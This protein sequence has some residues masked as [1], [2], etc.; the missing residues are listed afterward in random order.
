MNNVELIGRIATDVKAGNGVVSSLIAVHRI[1]KSKD[2]IEA[3]FIPLSLFG[4]Q[5]ENF[6]KM[7]QKGQQVGID[8][9]IKTSEYVDQNGEKRYGWSVVVSHF[10][11][12]NSGSHDG[13]QPKLSQQ[14]VSDSTHSA[15]H[16]P[17]QDLYN[18]YHH[19]QTTPTPQPVINKQLDDLDSQLVKAGIPFD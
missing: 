2:G 13:G 17:Q 6:S 1:Y 15:S 19:Q 10:Y 3:D 14:T 9:Q 8:G 7:V 16:N 12:L 18:Q 4:H 11:L 5:A